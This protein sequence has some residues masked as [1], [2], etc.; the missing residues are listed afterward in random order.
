MRNFEVMN[1]LS[2]AKANEKIKVNIC[3][4]IEELTSGEQIDKGLY[5]LCLDVC[6]FDSGTGII[7]TEV[8]GV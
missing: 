6:D 2:E 7:S 5:C 1:L 4:T 8:K 3:L